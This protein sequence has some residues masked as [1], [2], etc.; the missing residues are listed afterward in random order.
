MQ[1]RVEK[2][3]ASTAG[4]RAYVRQ[5]RHANMHQSTRFTFLLPHQALPTYALLWQATPWP[6]IKS[7]GVYASLSLQDLPPSQTCY[8]LLY[9]EIREEHSTH[10]W[11]VMQRAER[12]FLAV[13][14]SLT[15]AA[16]NTRL[17]GRVGAADEMT[18][19]RSLQ[20]PP[21]AQRF[22]QPLCLRDCC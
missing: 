10:T 6:S 13:V 16:I 2:S 8:Y 11:F 1:K 17:T 9:A 20:F 4:V 7:P 15:R 22:V 14:I 21:S 18:W 3:G 12:S 19:M 5:P